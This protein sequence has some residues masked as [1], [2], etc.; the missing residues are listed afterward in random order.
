MHDAA[1]ATLLR[2]LPSLIASLDREASEWGEPTAQGLLWFV[3]MHSF[4]ATAHLLHKV[5]PQV[6]RLSRVFQKE[7]VDFTLRR[8]CVDA[9][10]AAVSLYKDDDLKEVDSTL[11][12]DL[13]EYNIHTSD[14]MK[15]DF[16]KQIQEKYVVALVT[17]LTSRLPDVGEL[18][19]LSVL[20]PSKLPQESESSLLS[21]W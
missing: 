14:A 18:E 5:L 7:D 15:D 19:A 16:W 9:T 12:I 17:R 11:S 3:K 20:D 8:P 4:I 6:S 13:K 1:I 21:I 2:T 10:I